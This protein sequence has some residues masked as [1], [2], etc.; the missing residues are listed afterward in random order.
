MPVTFITHTQS[1]G[2]MSVR[3]K[4][5][6]SPPAIKF[7]T[8]GLMPI[9]TVETLRITVKIRRDAMRDA[10]MMSGRFLLF[11]ASHPERITGKSGRTQGANTVRIPEKNEIRII[12]ITLFEKWR[13]ERKQWLNMRMIVVERIINTES[14]SACLYESRSL[15]HRE[16]LRDKWWGAVCRKSDISGGHFWRDEEGEKHLESTLISENTKYLC[17]VLDRCFMRK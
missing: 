10:M 8:K 11:A 9:K 16:R 6:R 1:R 15:H 13:Q 7:H 5:T 4:S 2:N 14:F 3:E 17:P 12:V